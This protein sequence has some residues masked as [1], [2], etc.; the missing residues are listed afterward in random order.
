MKSINKHLPIRITRTPLLSVIVPCFQAETSLRRAINSIVQQG[1]RQDDLEIVLSVDDGR[2]YGWAAKIWPQTT[3]CTNLSLGTGPGPARN[4]GILA[5]SGKYLAFLDADDAWQL[6]YLDALMPVVAR[7]GLAFGM[8]E[9]RSSH[10]DQVLVLGQGQR[11]LRLQ[12]FGHWPGSFHPVMRRS[13]SPLF[14]NQPAQDVF[15]AMVVLAAY[16]KAA[17]LMGKARYLLYLNAT[18]VTTSHGFS[19]RIDRSYR[20]ML[21]ALKTWP[22]LPAYQQHQMKKALTMR[23]HWNRRYLAAND[24][25]QGR[26]S[27]YAFL[28]E[29]LA[30]KK[31]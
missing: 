10:G 3:I 5:A 7:H 27:F 23:L 15:H 2:D 13:D 18:S 17:P 11:Q 26:I 9:V 1:W 25:H 28:A 20:Q 6:G 31:N 24:R 30:Q 12:D 4:R 14:I 22:A 16:G 8:T 29:T 19:Q 21:S